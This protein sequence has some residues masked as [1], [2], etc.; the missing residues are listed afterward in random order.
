MMVYPWHKKAEHKSLKENNFQSIL[1]YSGQIS[2]KYE[3]SKTFW[4]SLDI[5]ILKI[6]TPEISDLI[7]RL[8]NI[9]YGNK[10]ITQEQ[11]RH[12]IKI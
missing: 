9:L 10:D 3:K 2:V 4:S 8:D 12:G 6:I 1:L 5:Q 7:K 11:A